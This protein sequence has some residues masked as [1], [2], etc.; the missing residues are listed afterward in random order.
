M[1]KSY[2]LYGLNKPGESAR[3]IGITGLNLFQRLS[4]HVCEKA[5]FRK[6]RWIQKML[7]N[8]QRPEIVPYCVGLIESEAKQLEIQVIYSLRQAGV[9]LVNS[10]DGGEGVTMTPEV[11]Q[12]IGAANTG[13][14]YC[15]GRKMSLETRKKIGDAHRGR[16]ASAQARERMSVSRLGNKNSVGNKNALGKKQSPEHIEKLA[17]TRRGRKQSPEHIE[18]RVAAIRGK[19]HQK[20][21]K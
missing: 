4:S 7:D 14:K 1:I 19:K 6:S 18:K 5:D 16:R 8:N 15:L 2:T 9:D 13:N 12:K 3:Y 17:A 11:R 10:G 21:N 20:K